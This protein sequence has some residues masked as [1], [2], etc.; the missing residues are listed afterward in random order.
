MYRTDSCSDQNVNLVRGT[1]LSRLSY[2]TFI[3]QLS[4]RGS[5]IPRS[6]SS[7]QEKGHYVC[8]ILLTLPLLAAC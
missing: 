6:E 1:I 4:C 5:A 3:A 7:Q 2:K 8:D